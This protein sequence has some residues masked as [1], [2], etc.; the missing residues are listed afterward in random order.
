M[1]AVVIAYKLVV[2][3]PA[4]RNTQIDMARRNR[5]S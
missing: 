3:T 1:M 5:P 4:V 2:D